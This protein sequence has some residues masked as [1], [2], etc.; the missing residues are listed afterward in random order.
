MVDS[1]VFRSDTYWTGREYH[2]Y[3]TSDLPR[4]L[5]FFE[6][7]GPHYA[8]TRAFVSQ[9][10]TDIAATA[11]LD[12]VARVSAKETE[13]SDLPTAA[14]KDQ[15]ADVTVPVL[16]SPNLIA[17]HPVSSTLTAGSNLQESLDENNRHRHVKAG[18]TSQEEMIGGTATPARTSLQAEAFDTRAVLVPLEK[19]GGDISKA[20]ST[21]VLTVDR[22]TE[23]TWLPPGLS[24]KRDSMGRFKIPRLQHVQLG[25]RPDVKDSYVNQYAL[26]DAAASAAASLAVLAGGEEAT[27]ESAGPRKRSKGLNTADQIKA[28]SQAP[29][30]FYWPQSRKKAVESRK[31][32]CGWCI[33]CRSNSRRGCLLNIAAGNLS[34]GVALVAGG[35]RPTKSGQN[36]LPALAAYVLYMEESLDGL[37][38]GPWESSEYRRQWRKRIEL[39]ESWNTVK[40]AVL[41]VRARKKNINALKMGRVQYTVNQ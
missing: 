6:D 32:R 31:E 40:V 11:S 18:T 36:H 14:S 25:A 12:S 35:L 29:A 21:G 17:S 20:T 30:Q 41:Q 5:K 9:W 2:L 16:C 15:T 4:L 39:A 27:A 19:Q 10:W 37:L 28:F 22:G 8:S 24:L 26:G 33:P 34:A 23:K 7:C 1:F 3:D 13:G 38:T